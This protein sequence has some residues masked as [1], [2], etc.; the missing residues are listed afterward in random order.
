MQPRNRKRL[1]LI[2]VASCFF[3]P[4]LVA[5]V[6]VAS[7]WVPGARSHGE[8]IVPQR[9]FDG[10]AVELADGTPLNWKDPDW[11]WM[12]VAVPGRTCAEA[13]QRQLDFVHRAHVSLNQNAMR[14]RLLYVGEPPAGEAAATLMQPWLLGRDVAGRLAEWAPA[15]DDGLA[16]VL[17]KPDGTALTV[18]R[19]GF[20]PSGLRKDLAKVTK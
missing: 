8:G 1:Q 11:R 14:L 20:D 16:V 4:M 3:V 2:L 17:V 10:I 13:C 9:S 6:L 18:Y 5:G 12:A 7:G 15:V 19:N